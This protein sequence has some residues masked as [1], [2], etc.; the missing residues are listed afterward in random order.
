[1]A[2][3]VGKCASNLEAFVSDTLHNAD[4]AAAGDIVFNCPYCGKSLAIDPRGAGMIVQCVDCGREIQVPGEPPEPPP[5]EVSAEAL[6][7]AQQKIER[8]VATIEELRER[9][10]HLEQLR[11]E[12][13]KRFDQIG[14]ELEIIQNALDRIVGLLQDARLETSPAEEQPAS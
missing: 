4:A 6:A 8:L 7:A 11:A 1:M 12:N 13:L 3:A 10:R 2:R 14:R 9:R 5:Q